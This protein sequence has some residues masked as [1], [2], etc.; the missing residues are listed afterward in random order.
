MNIS[1][2]ELNFSISLSLNFVFKLFYC[3]NFSVNYSK[4]SKSDKPILQR[5]PSIFKVKI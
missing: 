5:I 1:K 4:F 2:K 3:R